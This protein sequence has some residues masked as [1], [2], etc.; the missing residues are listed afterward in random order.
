MSRGYSFFEPS[1]PKAVT[2]GIKLQSSSRS[3]KK[4]WAKRWIEVLE[5]FN[6]GGRLTRGRTYANKGQVVDIRIEIGNVHARVQGSRSTPYEVSIS[7]TPLTDEQ[8]NGIAEV[9]S[10]QVIYAAKL[11]SGEMPVEI[12]EAFSA[13]K[14]SLFPVRKTDLK[15]S[16][17][18]PD[19]SNPCKH[20]AAVYYIIGDEFDRDPFLIFKLRGIDREGFLGKLAPASQQDE[21]QE[22]DLV[23]VSDQVP[24]SRSTRDYWRLRSD[25]ELPSISQSNTVHIQAALPKQLGTFPM[26]RGDQPLLETLARIYTRASTSVQN[27]KTHI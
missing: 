11:L 19:A 15:T 24:L 22:S 13:A 10:Q 4:W 21:E 1:R 7:L 14:L 16:C 17:S 27:A 26:W 20:I 5:S 9:V 23:T 3:Q 8:W 25:A 18:C 6:L 2:G 12:E